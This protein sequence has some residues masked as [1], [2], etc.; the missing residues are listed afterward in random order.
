M[1]NQA[2][3]YNLFLKENIIEE[4]NQL[5][6]QIHNCF[7][8]LGIDFN[9]FEI[10]DLKSIPI[11]DLEKIESLDIFLKKLSDIHPRIESSTEFL[12]LKES[13][14]YC[15]KIKKE[16]QE[17]KITL[18]REFKKLFSKINNEM[19]KTSANLIYSL[20][21]KTKKKH[22][23]NLENYFNFSDFQ[24]FI[25]DALSEINSYNQVVKLA[26]DAPHLEKLFLNMKNKVI[27]TKINIHSIIENYGKE[28]QIEQLKE[29]DIVAYEFLRGRALSKVAMEKFD[30]EVSSQKTYE[31][32][33]V[34]PSDPLSR[35]LKLSDSEI[36]IFAIAVDPIKNFGL[37]P[38]RKMES[39]LL[40]FLVFEIENE[41]KQMK[42]IQKINIHLDENLIVDI[43]TPVYISYIKAKLIKSQ[44]NQS[45]K[46]I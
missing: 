13:I 29:K 12:T 31:Q 30:I 5:I 38:G 2:S 37:I 32:R 41:Q 21:S 11:K 25:E 8:D 19:L 43:I 24:P 20:D 40:P 16:Y 35:L 23:E 10:G 3:L 44:Q 14:E 17:M 9:L 4:A 15:R 7:T 34:R 36:A 6:L 18:N 33:I 27:S 22:K 39:S 26:T 1:V 42:V 28:I 45:I 46:L